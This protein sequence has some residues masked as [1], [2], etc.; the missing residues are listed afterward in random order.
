MKITGNKA[1]EVIAKRIRDNFPTFDVVEY[2]RTEKQ[3]GDYIAV[4]FLTYNLQQEIGNIICNIN[5]HAKDKMSG[6]INSTQI[7][8]MANK[9]QTL[10][11]DAVYLDGNWYSIYSISG[12][13]KD[14]DKTHYVN[15][16]IEVIFDNIKE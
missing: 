11:N 12:I 8:S 5:V 2:E 13:T 7:W 16:R 10:F 3:K 1:V 14:E 15:I 9:V 4:N 6:E